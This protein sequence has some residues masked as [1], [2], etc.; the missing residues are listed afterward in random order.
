MVRVAGRKGPPYVQVCDFLTKAG[1]G[2]GCYLSVYVLST[3][4]P[5]GVHWMRRTAGVRLP[6]W[7][8]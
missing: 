5:R 1:L 6:G 8:T 3:K 4:P 2:D 7:R